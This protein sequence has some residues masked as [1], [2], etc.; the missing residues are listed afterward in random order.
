MA[1]LGNGQL[2]IKVKGQPLSALLGAGS[3]VAIPGYAVA[4]LSTTLQARPTFSASAPADHW[5]LATPA[6]TAPKLDAAAPGQGGGTLDQTPWDTAH[7]AASTMGYVHYVEPDVLH[8]RAT[9]PVSQAVEGLNPDWPPDVPDAVGIPPDWHLAKGFGDFEGERPQVTGKGIRIAHLDTGY[10]PQHASVPRNLNTALAYDFWDKKPGAVDPGAQFLGV[11]QP[12]HGTA[13]LALLAGNTMNLSFGKCTFKG[14]IGG[15]PD[16]EVIPVRISPSV[17]HL[18]TSTMAQGLLYAL[19]PNP[20]GTPVTTPERQCDVV[21]ISHG[22]LPSAAWAD[23]V[24]KIYEAGI[25]VVA[26]SGD[27]FNLGPADVFSHYTVYPS[28]FNR[29]ITA[30]GATYAKTPYISDKPTV[31]QGCWGPDIVMEKALAAYTP[32]VAWMKFDQVPNGFD[33]NGGGTSAST[34]Q[35][36]AACALWLQKYG[37][38]V[39]PDWRRVEACRLALFDGADDP[40]PNKPELGWGMLNAA[41]SLEADVVGPIIA[42]ANAVAPQQGLAASA[43]DSVSSPFWRV[44]FGWPPPQS[45]QERMYET[46]VE[47]IVRTSTNIQLRAGAALAASGGALNAGDQAKYRAFLSVEPM[48]TALRQR[49]GQAPPPPAAPKP[50]P[51]APQA[52]SPRGKPMAKTKSIVS[53]EGYSALI[54]SALV[55]AVFVLNW[56]GLKKYD[57]PSGRYWI[58]LC[59][60]VLVVGAVA[61]IGR[62]LT[63]RPGGL[64]IDNKNVM[65]LSRLQMLIWML[66][67]LPAL[68]TAAAANLAGIGTPASLHPLDFSIPNE[69]L[70]A[71]GLAGV[72]FVG[73]P[74]VL[75]SKMNA[76]AHPD[77]LPSTTRQLNLAPSETGANGKVFTKSA[78]G[79]ASWADLFRGDE[80]GNA[81]TVDLGKIQQL[82][83]TLL[84]A[85]IYIG[86]LA[87]MFSA[88]S[89]IGE[90]P[91]LSEKFVWLLAVSQGT[92]LGAAAAPHTRDAAK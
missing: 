63:G 2:L 87:E 48:S 22:G 44:L 13:T 25:V 38:Q 69:L 71:L 9:L 74:I 89:S 36:A 91:A 11:L 64:L 12:G 24:N 52:P 62:T 75:G 86:N 45:E 67:I 32:N 79:L 55:G 8:A 7:A 14:D 65:S 76:E 66:V 17:V 51:P 81:D 41:R 92:Y 15:A 28:A 37:A 56:L 70:A 43:E 4:P 26:A 39:P 30:L 27:N 1:L 42:K 19:A 78:P 80:V 72:A 29:V 5:L 18:Y 40:Q 68:V 84:L 57:I 90:F 35:I 61:S 53:R 73:S 46:E 31:M 21:T 50:L 88:T 49:I 82:L 85:G 16:A 10:T 3:P 20:P 83:V 33:M 58:W 47:Q 60:L 6:P 34:P 59:T 23:A 54:F 77:E